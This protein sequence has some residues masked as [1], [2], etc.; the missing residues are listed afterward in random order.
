MPKRAATPSQPDEPSAVRPSDC[1]PSLEQRFRL[2]HSVWDGQLELL[3]REERLPCL[4][5]DTFDGWYEHD[6]AEELAVKD[7]ELVEHIVRA[8]ATREVLRDIFMATAKGPRDRADVERAVAA[9]LAAKR[10]RRE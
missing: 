4:Q 2:V 5:Y 10:A 6:S 9:H 1:A 7:M 3:L 8:L